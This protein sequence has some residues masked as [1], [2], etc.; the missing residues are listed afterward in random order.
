MRDE[1]N[2]PSALS[3]QPSSLLIL[4]RLQ[5]RLDV[6]R[7]QVHGEQVAEAF[8]IRVALELGQ[9]SVRHAALEFGHAFRSEFAVLYKLRVAL[10]DRFREQFAAGDLDAELPFQAEDDVQEVDRL[11]A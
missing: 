8:E 5:L 11:G 9:V 6:A 3:P 2:H 7:G 10:E 4:A 1:S